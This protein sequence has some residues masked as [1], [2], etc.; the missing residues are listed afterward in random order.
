M[1]KKIQQLT[2]LLFLFFPLTLSAGEHKPRITLAEIN[3]A[4]QEWGAAIVE[5]GAAEDPEAVAKAH[6]AE[7]YAYDLGT[8]LF[9]P[10]KAA[11][12]QFRGDPREALS[13]FVTGIVSEDGG[14]A[15]APYSQVRFENEDVIV[16]SDSALAMGNYYFTT[17]GGVEVKVEY[18]FG[19]V[20]GPSG[21]LK[22]NLHHSSFPYSPE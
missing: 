14:F 15:L 19:Y 8:V 21:D 4:Q 20:R 16:D 7:L 17:S 1:T 12:D 22:I 3:E 13:Y 2:A 18:T 10:T 5:I 6:I 9:K 11:A